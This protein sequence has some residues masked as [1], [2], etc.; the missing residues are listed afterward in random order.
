MNLAVP[1]QQETGSFTSKY[2][3]RLLKAYVKDIDGLI[4]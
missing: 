2:W 1:E 4:S 3:K